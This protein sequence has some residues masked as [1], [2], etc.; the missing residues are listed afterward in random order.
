MGT[1]TRLNWHCEADRMP[2]NGLAENMSQSIRDVW[3]YHSLHSVL[4]AKPPCQVPSPAPMRGDE[5]Q[6]SSRVTVALCPQ[7]EVVPGRIHRPQR[8]SCVQRR[9]S[10]CL[11]A[12]HTTVASG[13]E[14]RQFPSVL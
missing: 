14:I 12:Q 5:Q 9:A 1:E 4:I 7:S 2:E 10:M 6:D 13:T 3:D 8:N 11:Q